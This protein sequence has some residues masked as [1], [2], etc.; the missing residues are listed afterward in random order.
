MSDDAPQPFIEDDPDERERRQ[1]IPETSLA[2]I[3]D[4][5]SITP[6]T[7]RAATSRATF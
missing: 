1:P 7:C 4:G 6:P 2:L 3:T 5:R